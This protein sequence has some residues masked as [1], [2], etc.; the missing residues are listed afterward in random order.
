MTLL[1]PVA[2]L[3]PALRETGRDLFR[4]MIRLLAHK[5]PDRMTSRTS[6][7]RAGAVAVLA[8]VAL[9]ACQRQAVATREDNLAAAGFSVEPANTPQLKAML[10]RLPANLFVIRQNGSV[11][12]Y[13]YAHPLVCGCLQV[14]TQAQY[15]H[16]VRGRQTQDM[17]DKQRM[18]AQMY[19]DANWNRGPWGPSMVS[20]STAAVS[21]ARLGE[22]RTPDGRAGAARC[23]RVSRCRHRLAG[24]RRVDLRQHLVDG[25]VTESCMS[26]Q[27]IA[28]APDQK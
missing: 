5:D 24:E 20:C 13:V 19:Q 12:H 7:T 15:D 28:V 3:V 27:D 16:D 25:T 22:L 4:P 23:G 18:T 8:V 10:N 1:N 2:R 9:S 14:G 26:G 11:V 6:L 17:I 21:R